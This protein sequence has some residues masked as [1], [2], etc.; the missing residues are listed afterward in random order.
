MAVILV[1]TAWAVVQAALVIA[2]IAR[3]A[4]QNRPC[5]FQGLAHIRL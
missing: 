2:A 1:V 3:P 4:P 5:I